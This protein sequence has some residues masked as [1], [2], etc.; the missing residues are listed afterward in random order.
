MSYSGDNN[1][2]LWGGPSFPPAPRWGIES[3]HGEHIAIGFAR[4]S[5][6]MQRAKEIANSTGRTVYVYRELR[7][8]GP[9]PDPVEIEPRT[10]HE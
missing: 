5:E 3:A 2:P 4:E 1:G 10:E 7:E 8:V 9:D 6:A